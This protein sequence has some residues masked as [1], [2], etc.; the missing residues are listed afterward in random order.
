MV[1]YKEYTNKQYEAFL[2]SDFTNNFGFN[3][4]TFAGWFMSQPGSGAVRRSYGV[5]KAN[6]LSTYIPNLKAKLNGG[7]AMFLM[8]TVT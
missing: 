3:E 7:W 1:K 4:E 5:T 2:K 8:I 6:L